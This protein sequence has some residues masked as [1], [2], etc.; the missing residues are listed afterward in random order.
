MYPWRP[1]PRRMKAES[2]VWPRLWHYSK[3]PGGSESHCLRAQLHCSPARAVWISDFTLL[4]LTSFVCKVGV[5]IPLSFPHTSVA[6][7]LQ[8][9]PSPRDCEKVGLLLYGH[10]RSFSMVSVCP[11]A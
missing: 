8:S 7:E 9:H 11:R 4:N 1:H 5:I 3:P 10:Q 2:V 6:S